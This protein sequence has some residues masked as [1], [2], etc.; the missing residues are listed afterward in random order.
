M[1]PHSVDSI[2]HDDDELSCIEVE[3][4]HDS[5]GNVVV[6]KIVFSKLDEANETI[7]VPGETKVST[8]NPLTLSREMTDEPSSSSS[9][10]N[11]YEVITNSILLACGGDYGQTVPEAKPKS[12]LKRDGAITQ[13]RSVSFKSLEIREYNMTLGDHPSAYSGPPVTLDWNHDP[14]VEVVD[15]D[16][17]EQARKPRRNRKQLKLSSREREELLVEG[18]FSMKDIEVAWN[19]AL[20]IRKQR[21]ETVMQGVMSTKV[22]EA[23]ESANR[24][25][26][27]LFNYDC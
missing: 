18:G 4:S 20:K 10:S 22:E 15:V 8:I 21:Y 19:S 11:L 14:H 24:K 16:L 17:Y 23:L 26:W 13:Q 1:P 25:F 7:E 12:A 5:R 6:K 3:A 2:Y 9:T 27:R